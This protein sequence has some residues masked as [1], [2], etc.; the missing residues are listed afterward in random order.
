MK[1]RPPEYRLKA[2]ADDPGTQQPA[3]L[4][5]GS[6][7]ELRIVSRRDFLELGAGVI[8]AG[9]LLNVPALRA[10]PQSKGSQSVASHGHPATGSP[11]PKAVIKAHASGIGI[12]KISADGKTLISGSSG[13]D[14]SIK[15]WSWGH[16]A[17]AEY[18]V[19]SQR[20]A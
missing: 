17:G 11:H 1:P 20:G 15:L 16:A 2:T 14:R 3:L 4:A 6:S 13:S 10:D 8:G 18:D 19:D 5:V 7:N 9:A 12:L